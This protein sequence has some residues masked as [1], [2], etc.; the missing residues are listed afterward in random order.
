[1][2]EAPSSDLKPIP[3]IE[4]GHAEDLLAGAPQGFE[5]I[6]RAARERYGD[7][8]ILLADRLSRRW[9]ARSRNPL[10][11]EMDAVARRLGRPGAF[12]LNLSYLWSCTTGVGPDPGR[13][14]NRLRRTLDWPL[15]GLGRSLVMARA[16]PPAGPYYAATWPGY[17]GVLT[18]MAPGRFSAAINQPPMDRHTGWRNLDWLLNR[19]AVWRR[20]AL[21]PDHL[22]RRVF[23]VAASY[24]EAR[25]LL[26][27]SPLSLPAFFTLGGLAP[28]Q[29]CII[30]RT[31]DGAAVADGPGCAANHWRLLPVRGHLR[32]TNSAGRH[33]HMTAHRDTPSGGFAWVVPPVLNPT[34]RVAAVMNAR[35]GRFDLMG[36]E[37]EAP[38]TRPFCL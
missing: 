2:P 12:F 17:V 35:E 18:A 38:A 24:D 14:G 10:L 9:M 15:D 30:E 19:L 32:G 11:A 13:P 26:L 34:T 4:S 28:D 27:E 3:L 21:P 36:W 33:D 22:L 37:D 23:E 31:P 5:T 25:R 1:M 16:Q 6:M 29:C 8:T 7:R 20:R